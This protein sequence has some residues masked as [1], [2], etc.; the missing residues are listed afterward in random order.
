VTD[1]ERR[2]RA[3]VDAQ[4]S[5]GEIRDE[6]VLAAMATVPRERFVPESSWPEAYQEH[7]LP[8]G[9]DQTISQ[10]YVVALMTDALELEP[11]DRVLEV[12]TGSGYQTAV[13]RELVGELVTIERID[14]LAASAR[15][16]FADLGLQGIDVVV[17][18]GTLGWPERAPYDAIVVTAG[19]PSIPKAL[20]DQLALGGRLV[21]PV[22][23]AGQQILVRLRR[24][25]DGLD[26]VDD[27]GPVAF[28]PLIGEEGW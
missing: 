23:S 22:G 28:V 7:A 17:G 4:R 26:V 9:A 1:F 27:L 3:M 15:A 20:R 24:R 12:G 18:D 13:L 21:M 19:G 8:I 11:S 2:R 14:S 6:R 16:R 5:R 10:P 25:N